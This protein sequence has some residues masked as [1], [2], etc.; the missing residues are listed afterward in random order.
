M[1][2]GSWPSGVTVAVPS[3]STWMR[4]EKVSATTGP[5]DLDSTTG[6]SP[7]GSA[8]K[9][10]RF[11]PI[12]HGNKGLRNRRMP[13]TQVSRMMGYAQ[14]RACYFASIAL[15]GTEGQMRL[16]R[17]EFIALVGGAA[18]WP[19]A[20]RAQQGDRVRRIGVLMP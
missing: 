13:R 17:R 4:P 1:K 14:H 18:A 2:N 11:V 9:S 20:A 16:R 6:C 7:I 5:A 3:H 19:L 8:G 15:P 10:P 12:P